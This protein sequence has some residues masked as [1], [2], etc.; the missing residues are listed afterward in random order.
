MTVVLFSLMSSNTHADSFG[1][2]LR[3]WFTEESIPGAT[4]VNEIFATVLEDERTEVPAVTLRWSPDFWEDHDILL[5]YFKLDPERTATTLV[6]VSVPGT[7]I[8]ADAATDRSDLELLIRSRVNENFFFYYGLRLIEAEVGID[9]L[10]DPPQRQL[11]QQDWTLVEVG[12]GTSVPVSENGRHSLFA[13]VIGGY[14]RFEDTLSNSGMVTSSSSENG[15][16]IDLNFGYQYTINQ[17]ASFSL[18]YRDW[19]S[20]IDG[21]PAID[22]AGIDLGITFNF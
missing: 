6:A 22:S 11:V 21:D 7:F 9:I 3:Y 4:Q 13:N 19:A 8:E 1:V 12:L 10:T 5:S 14:G 18:R 16:T 20:Y 2:T 15:H 17:T